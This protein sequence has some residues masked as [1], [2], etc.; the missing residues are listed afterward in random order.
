I[1]IRRPILVDW[2]AQ[3]PAPL[4]GV[5]AAVLGDGPLA[6]AMRAELS[7]RGAKLAEPPEVVLDCGAEVVD[8]LR[9][10]QSWNGERSR[11]WIAVTQLGGFG[12]GASG[13]EA[14]RA[15]AR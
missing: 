15:G 7:R 1:R 2:P 5:R 14:M 10:A 3:P 12:E 4:T 11:V 9:A 8:L 6:I 13:G